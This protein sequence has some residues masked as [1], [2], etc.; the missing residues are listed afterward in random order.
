MKLEWNF[1]AESYLDQL[2]S[3]ERSRV[4]HAVERLPTTW[5]SLDGTRL[6]R[7]KGDQTD[8]FSLRVVPTCACSCGGETTS[9]PWSTS[10]EGAKSTGCAG[11]RS[12]A[13]PRLDEDV[14]LAHP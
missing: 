4:L 14:R 5:D 11:P 1:T 12:S 13:R 6:N 7:L 3:T 10:F 8:L 9:S 2:P